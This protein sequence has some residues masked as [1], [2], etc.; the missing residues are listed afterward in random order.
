MKKIATGVLLGAM[1][2]VTGCSSMAEK[3]ENMMS[4]LHKTQLNDAEIMS[5]LNTANMG[6]ISQGQIALQKAQNVQVKNFAKKM[7]TEHTNN[8]QKGQALGSRLGI[9]PQN[10]EV[11]TK[12]KK[13][14][15]DVV[16]KLNKTDIK[17]FDKEYIDSQIKVHKMVLKTIDDKLLPNAQNA[18]LRTLLTQTRPTI[19]QHLQMA[20][21][22]KNNLK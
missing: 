8:Y 12:L 11:S 17:D 14:S 15:D 4:H 3:T 1:V 16:N 7:V 5:V 18:E 2:V 13:D 21:L 20:E 10:N 6:E 22:I 9:T 19:A